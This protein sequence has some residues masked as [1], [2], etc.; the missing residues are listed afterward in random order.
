MSDRPR[1]LA[2][3]PLVWG[4]SEINEWI[5]GSYPSEARSTRREGKHAVRV[6]GITAKVWADSMAAVRDRIS[7]TVKGLGFAITTEKGSDLAAIKGDRRIRARFRRSI[8][9]DS[10]TVF[11]HFEP[12]VHLS[13]VKKVVEDLTEAFPV[14]KVSLRKVSRGSSA[15]NPRR[16]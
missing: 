13:T 16:D 9:S 6:S 2:Q 8:V 12:P 1:T 5:E 15:R 10:V 3:P 7:E 4:P 14:A 11:L